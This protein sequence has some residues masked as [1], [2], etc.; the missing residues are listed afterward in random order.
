MTSTTSTRGTGANQG[1][2]RAFERE[3]FKL[4]ARISRAL[5]RPMT[6]LSFAWLVLLV[7]D[8][9]RGLSPLLDRLS[10]AIWG[11]FVLQF[12]IEF[13]V[14]P[15]KAVYLR[16]NWLTAISL[17]LPAARL[18]RAVRVVRAARGLGALRGARLVRIVSGAN[19]GMRALARVMGRRGFG[20]VAMLTLLVT[21]AGAS[22]MYAFER[23]V[24]ESGIDS[25]GSA[26]WW[27]AMTLTTMGAD[28]FPKTPE[29]RLLCL[30]LAVYGFA[31]FGYVTASVASFFVARD[32]DSDAT[33]LAGARQIEGLRREIAALR[34]SLERVPT[35]P[36]AEIPREG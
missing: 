32:A 16:R 24:P 3:R 23:G 18:F 9:T 27:T 14:A 20:Y 33:E 15:R 21:V 12:V 6:V 13:V 31:I 7:V 19:R 29:G 4:A 34:S 1:D 22:G 11:L 35:G 28:T 26:L 17:V 8:L 25:F 2:E 30:L 5:A 36:L 10:Y